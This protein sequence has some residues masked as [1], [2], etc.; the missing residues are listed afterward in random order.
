MRAPTS[1]PNPRMRQPV[2]V[3]LLSVV[4]VGP[5]ACGG[6]RGGDDDDASGDG[7]ADADADADG[8]AD[9]D[10]DTDGDAD[11]AC[12]P[13]PGGDVVQAH[14]DELVIAVLGGGGGAT[15]V[16]VRGRLFFG[17]AE[18]TC[19]RVGSVEIHDGR[20]PLQVLDGLPAGL[21]L[22]GTTG[23]VAEGP[24]DAALS[25]R[26]G[27][28]EGWADRYGL[29]VR[30]EVDGGTYEARC[31]T[32]D[33]GTGWPPR[34]LLSCHEGLAEPPGQGNAMVTGGEGFAW[35]D[36]YVYFDHP[37]G[38]AITGVDGTLRILP[39]LD[40][41][42]FGGPVSPF[43]TQGWT[44]SVNETDLPGSGVATQVN[45]H[46]DGD[47][48]GLDVC[49]VTPPQPD[50]QAPLP[51]VFLARMT[52]TTERGAFSSEVYVRMCTRGGN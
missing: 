50:P 3:W 47:P 48:L 42:D 34:V 23:L 32:L 33:D 5:L 8:D 22:D 29:V 7:D 21:A 1:A 37:E 18:G 16:Q 45:L 25:A 52:G 38:Q 9:A 24:A 27:T 30:G 39:A 26:C 15:R 49:P 2:A 41:F 11:D 31:G 12:V 51:P 14:C 6:G 46:A 43:D 19:A 13:E 44:A 40:P 4:S 10:A 35:T 36:L 17:L 28:D 20:E